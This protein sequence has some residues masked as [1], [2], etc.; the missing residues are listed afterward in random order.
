MPSG[1]VAKPEIKDNKDGTVTVNFA[2]NEA[3]IHEMDIKYDSI[4]IPG[5][6]I[7]G[8]GTGGLYDVEG[9]NIVHAYFKITI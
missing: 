1:K 9:L 4:H 2:P 5:E 3:G 7:S 8:G 6:L